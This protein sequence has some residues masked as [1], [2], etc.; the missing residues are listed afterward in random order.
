MG[1]CPCLTAGWDRQDPG[2]RAAKCPASPGCRSRS[3]GIRRRPSVSIHGNMAPP[4]FAPRLLPW[5]AAR[6]AHL[7]R[8]MAVGGLRVPPSV[9]LSLASAGIASGGPLVQIPGNPSASAIPAPSGRCRPGA[10]RNATTPGSVTSD[11]HRAWGILRALKGEEVPQAGN[12]DHSLSPTPK[13]ALG[14]GG[15][16]TRAGRQVEDKV[17]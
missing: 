11:P 2:S 8:A 1:S 4:L 17:Y 7:A 12:K 16:K 6:R 3:E 14:H 5:A 9:G 10:P 15:C 13:S